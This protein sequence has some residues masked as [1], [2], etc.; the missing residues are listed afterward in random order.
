MPRELLEARDRD[1]SAHPQTPPASGGPQVTRTE[2]P[3][4]A[5]VGHRVR[6]TTRVGAVMAAQAGVISR[7]QVLACGGDDNLIERQLRRRVWAVVHRGVYVDH[8]GPLTWDQRSWAALLYYWPA[9][10]SHDSALQAHGIRPV[11]RSHSEAFDTRVHVAVDQTRR[12]TELPGVRLHRVTGLAQLV[13][14]NRSPARIRLEESLLAVASASQRDDEAVAVLAD[15]VQTRRTT[16]GRLLAALD[17]RPKLPRRRFLRTVLEDVADG[18]YSVLERR[19]LTEVERPHGL[20]TASR[21]RRASA[22]GGAAFRDVEYVGQRL[23]VELDGRL[24]HELAKDRWNDLG[25]DL[26]GAVAGVRTLRI[27]WRQ[28]LDPCRT[29]AAVAA[30]LAA[31]GWLGTPRACTPSCPVGKF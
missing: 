26:S 5:C 21:Q 29:A 12:V 20:P 10:L 15:A 3:S 19:Y 23:V 25:R 17:R 27:G 2:G 8:T 14:A 22:G 24:A 1:T 31:Q 9:A 6:M 16:P 18:A 7:R 11:D 28:V 4:R 30:I 13:Q